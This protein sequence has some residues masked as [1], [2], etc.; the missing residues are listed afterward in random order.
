MACL[1]CCM[2]VIDPSF[3]TSDSGRSATAVSILADLASGSASVLTEI[4][5]AN[6]PAAGSGWS[7]DLSPLNSFLAGLAGSNSAVSRRAACT[8]SSAESSSSQAASSAKAVATQIE[9]DED[10]PA[11]IGRLPPNST[12]MPGPCAPAAISCRSTPAG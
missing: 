8:R 10:S 1:R 11:P 9:A 3:V 5:V 6:L 7:V 2:S 12:S 4:V